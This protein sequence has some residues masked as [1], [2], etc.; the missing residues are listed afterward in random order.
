MAWGRQRERGGATMMVTWAELLCSPGHALD[1]RL[2]AELIGAGF[3]SFRGSRVRA[4]LR[5][6]RLGVRLCRPGRYLPHAAGRLLRGLFD[7]ERGLE[8]R[9]SDSL[10]AAQS[11]WRAG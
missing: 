11:S 8:W 3:D 1:E 4:H 10:S 5:Q 6:A 2:E 9:C 7:S